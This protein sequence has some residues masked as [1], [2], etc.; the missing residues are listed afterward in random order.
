MKI[1]KLENGRWIIAH[2]N[3]FTNQFTTSV[4]AYYYKLTGFH[5]TVA[6]TLEYLA[7][8]EGVQTYSTYSNAKRALKRDYIPPWD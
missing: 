2:Y 8:M 1:W 7:K 6:N 5:T 3:Y 4:N